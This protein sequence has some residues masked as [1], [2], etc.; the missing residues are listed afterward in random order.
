MSPGKGVRVLSIC[1]DDGIRFSRDLVLKHE[2]YDVESVA[3]NENLD[4]A[5]VRCFHVA[6]LCHSLSPH[7]AAEIARIL[8]SCNPDIGIL[9]V[10]AIRSPLDHFYDVDC[11]VLPGPGQLLSAIHTLAA[12]DRV[13]H[14]IEER[15]SA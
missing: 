11:E 15:Q 14:G 4:A 8:R 2:G 3:S 7:R 10:H 1:D 5:Q 12:R 6:I 9:R 13:P